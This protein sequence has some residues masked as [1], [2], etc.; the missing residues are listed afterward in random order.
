MAT[1]ERNPL[2]KWARAGDVARQQPQKK[3]PMEGKEAFDDVRAQL[4]EKAASLG[5]DLSDPRRVLDEPELCKLL[6]PGT[7]A[8]YPPGIQPAPTRQIREFLT[9]VGFFCDVCVC[10]KGVNGALAGR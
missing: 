2:A 6:F 5:V 3:D 9:T 10:R 8:V 7:E 1:L 4:Q